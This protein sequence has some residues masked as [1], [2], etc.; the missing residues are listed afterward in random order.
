MDL[1]EKLDEILQM[2]EINPKKESA[3]GKCSG[4]VFVITGD[5]MHYKN[6]KEFKDYVESQGGKVSGSVSKKTNY[7]VNNDTESESSKN[8]TAKELGVPIISEDEF[9]K[10]FN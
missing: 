4:L 1:F 10:M 9:I 7:L 8:R 5:V 6:R 3:D 2:K